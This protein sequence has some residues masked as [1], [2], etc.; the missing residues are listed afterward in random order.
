MSSISILLW[1]GLTVL[2]TVP[3]TCFVITGAATLHILASMFVWAVTFFL[4]AFTMSWSKRTGRRPEVR[5]LRPR[6]S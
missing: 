2:L 5:R 4:V 3:L 6:P 1:A